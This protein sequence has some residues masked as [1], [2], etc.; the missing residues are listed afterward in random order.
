M[1]L[2]FFRLAFV[3]CLLLAFLAVSCAPRYEYKPVPLRPM[4]G[5]PSQSS[6]QEGK[7][8]VKLFYDDAEIKKIFGFNLKNAGVIPVQLLVENHLQEGSITILQ[9]TLTDSNNNVWEVL[10][11][12]VVYQRLEEHTSGGSSLGHSARR[13]FL[14]SLAG[15]VLGAAV[16]VV[17][18]TNVG[19]AAGK[20][21]AVGAAIGVATSIG[22]QSLDNKKDDNLEKD[23]SE[24]SFEHATIEPSQSAH[25]LLY[26]PS[27]AVNPVSFNLTIK[28]GSNTRQLEF[29]F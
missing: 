27:E 13:T 2:K 11:A 23:F 9:A 7:I 6:F 22:E 4:S 24:R 29:G 17:S 18:G 3:P 21:A 28:A 16:G 25:G 10:P 26:F 14:W 19:T 8:G 15:G 12:D 1:P 5:Y 20:G